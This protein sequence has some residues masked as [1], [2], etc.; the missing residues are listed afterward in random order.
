MAKGDGFWCHSPYK[1]HL[2]VQQRCD[3]RVDCPGAEDESECPS[4]SGY[5]SRFIENQVERGNLLA[6]DEVARVENQEVES[7]TNN[8][9]FAATGADL[10]RHFVCKRI[11][12][13]I[14]EEKWC[15]N[16]H[17]CEDA[18]DEESCTCKDYIRRDHS[19]VICDG[20]VDCDDGSDEE[21][22]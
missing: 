1:K 18:S 12:Q 8:R 20:H 16:V 10:P 17:D 4:Y 14:A 15:D 2:S 7:T 9:V 11:I 21:G 5:Y 3:G 6:N 13:T 22:C 19:D